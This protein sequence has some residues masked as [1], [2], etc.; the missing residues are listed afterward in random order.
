LIT[1]KFIVAINEDAQYV[2]EN[3]LRYRNASITFYKADWY[4]EYQK[5]GPDFLKE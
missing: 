3:E 2:I 5:W 1:K 4:T